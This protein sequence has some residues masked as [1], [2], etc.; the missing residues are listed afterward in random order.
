MIDNAEALAPARGGAS[1][2]QAQ[3]RLAVANSSFQL[4][5][6]PS[7]CNSSQRKRKRRSKHVLGPPELEPGNEVP[8]LS[9]GALHHCKL[10][11]GYPAQDLRLQI[12]R[13]RQELQGRQVH[14]VLFPDVRKGRPAQAAG[15]RLPKLHAEGVVGQRV[16][17]GV[18]V[19]GGDR[20]QR[21]GEG[22]DARPARAWPV[23]VTDEVAVKYKEVAMR[24]EPQNGT[25]FD[26]PC[27]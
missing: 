17:R 14:S 24:A 18:Q 16:G 13:E 10:C 8:Q 20:R 4:P 25:F 1:R 19:P 11:Y 7:T 22:V 12:G 26:L 27:A 23:T 15:K 2:R 21:H 3:H 6:Q 5:L 9:A